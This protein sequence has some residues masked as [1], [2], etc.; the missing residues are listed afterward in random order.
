MPASLLLGLLV[1]ALVQF[2][3]YSLAGSKPEACLFGFLVG[4]IVMTILHLKDDYTQ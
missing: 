3:L 2:L 1:N 4:S